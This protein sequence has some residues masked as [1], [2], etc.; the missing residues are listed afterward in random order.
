MIIIKFLS[1]YPLRSHI[2]NILRYA[3]GTSHI[4]YILDNQLT[5]KNKKFCL[6]SFVIAVTVTI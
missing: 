6:L 3:L 5:A 1:L 4:T 2:G